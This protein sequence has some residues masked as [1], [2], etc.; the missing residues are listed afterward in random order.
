MLFE[1]NDMRRYPY[2]N[3]FP[4]SIYTYHFF[5]PPIRKNNKNICLTTVVCDVTSLNP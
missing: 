2:V 4:M 5:Q 1:H 3:K